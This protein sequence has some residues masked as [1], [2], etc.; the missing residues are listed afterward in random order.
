MLN[1][2]KKFITINVINSTQNKKR[3]IDNITYNCKEHHYQNI[4]D[5]IIYINQLSEANNN[6]NQQEKI[7]E[8]DDTDKKINNIIYKV[9]II[10][11]IVK[12]QA[13]KEITKRI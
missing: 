3:K 10:F 4:Y 7:K 5:W 6:N 12:F 11:P 1:K 8:V 2:Y 13:I 9:K